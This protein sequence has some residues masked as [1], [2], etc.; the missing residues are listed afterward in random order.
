M[1]TF[2]VGPKIDFKKYNISSMGVSKQE[3]EMT[4]F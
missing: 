4:E 3:L 2:N 1:R